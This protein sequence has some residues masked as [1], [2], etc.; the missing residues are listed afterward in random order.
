MDTDN[1]AFTNCSNREKG[2]DHNWIR[3]ADGTAYC[4]SCATELDAA[5]TSEAWPPQ[6][7]VNKKADAA[8]K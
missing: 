2:P 5:Q 4:T 7:Q 6:T 3:R 1:P 8:K